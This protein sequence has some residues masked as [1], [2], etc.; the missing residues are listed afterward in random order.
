MHAKITTPN[1]IAAWLSGYYNAKRTTGLLIVNRLVEFGCRDLLKIAAVVKPVTE[2]PSAGGYLRGY[3]YKGIA[4]STLVG[5][6]KLIR[7]P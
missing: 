5:Q 4:F 1:L 3:Q 7:R 6:R 2:I